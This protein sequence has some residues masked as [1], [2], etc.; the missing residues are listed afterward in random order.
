M[1]KASAK[2]LQLRGKTAVFIDWAN[3]YGWRKSLK[4]EV[5]PRKLVEYFKG[6][7]KIRHLNFYYGEDKHPKSRNFLKSVGKLGYTITSKPVKYICIGVV[8]GEK[9]LK[10]KCDFDM[11]ICIDVHKFLNKRVQSYVF[12]T[13]D[14]D[15]EPLYKLLIS[16]RKQLVVVYAKGHLGKEVWELKKGIFKTEVGK[17]G[18]VF[19]KNVPPQSGGRDYYEV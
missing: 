2:F 13:G 7:K 3:V 11:E 15:F 19:K 12:L 9:I 6:Y 10:R 4:R 18:R 17:F 14:G 16:L 1:A 5:D 8:N